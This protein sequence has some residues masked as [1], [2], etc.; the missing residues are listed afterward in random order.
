MTGN[1]SNLVSSVDHRFISKSDVAVKIHIHLPDGSLSHQSI[2]F[3]KSNEREALEKA[4][5]ISNEIGE[6]ARG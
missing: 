6:N 4:I 2:G 5:S 1:K 3:I